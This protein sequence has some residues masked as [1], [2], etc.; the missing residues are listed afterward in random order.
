MSTTTLKIEHPIVDFDTWRAAFERDPIGREQ[1][2]VLAHRV[3]RPLDDPNYVLID[4]DFGSVA[5][6]KSFLER[7]EEVWSRRELSPG[8]ERSKAPGTAAVPRGRVVQEV[9]RRSY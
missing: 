4:L 8:L 9:E 1:S 2:G 5:Q 6:A 3:S 7:L